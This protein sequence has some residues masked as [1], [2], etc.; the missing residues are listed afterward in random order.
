M[1]LMTTQLDCACIGGVVKKFYRYVMLSHR[2]E[3]DEPLLQ[4]VKNISIYELQKFCSLVRSLGFRWAWSDTCRVDKSNDVVLQE[5]LV[6]MF[7]WYRR[8]PLPVVYLH[9]VRRSL[10]SPVFSEASG[11]LEDGHTKNMLLLRPSGSTLK[12]GDHTS[13]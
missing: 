7:M 5:S 12:T 8:S 11:T 10:S 13:A 6:A 2:W 9:D 4:K 3:E 1:S